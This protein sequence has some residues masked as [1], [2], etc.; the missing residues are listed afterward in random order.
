MELNY[1]RFGIGLLITSN[2]A[3]GNSQILPQ[4]GY[5]TRNSFS[6]RCNQR[7]RFSHHAMRRRVGQEPSRFASGIG[8]AGCAWSFLVRNFATQRA[9]VRHAAPIGCRNSLP[10]SIDAPNAKIRMN[11]DNKSSSPTSVACWISAVLKT[12]NA[13]RTSFTARVTISVSSLR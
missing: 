1:G 3:D 5:Q 7:V 8:C 12:S 9:I 2:E 13:A 10:T 11:E 6:E 4:I